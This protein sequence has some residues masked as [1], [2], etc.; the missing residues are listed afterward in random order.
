MAISQFIEKIRNAGLD[1]IVENAFL[2]YF[3]QVEEGASGKLSKNEIDAPAESNVINY[4]EIE[5]SKPAPIDKLAVIKLNGGLG[6]SMGLSQA[7]TLL[8]VKDNLNFLDIIA[9]QILTLRDQTQ[10]DIPLIF[11]HSF[12][13]QKDSLEYLE[14]YKDLK[15]ENIPLDFLQNKFPKVRQSD[16]AP[17]I[18]KDD[19]KTWNPPGHG[20][21][22]MALAITGTLDKLLAAGK[23]YAFLS[24][25]D[26]LG[27]VVDDKILGY[28]A[29]NNLPF[30]ME[31]CTRTEMDKKGG[32]LAQTHDGQLIL[33]ETAQCP[34]DEKD[35]FE[36][37]HYYKYFNTNNLWINLKI[38]KEELDK[39]GNFL[40][41]SLIIN[42]KEVDGIKVFQLESAMGAAISVFKNSKAMVVH[43]DRFAPVKKTDD[44]FVVRSD[45][46]KLSSNYHL[47]LATGK[48]PIV[49][50]DQKY[51][52]MV[53]EFETRFLA[54]VPSLK[55][56]EKFVL[57]GDVKFGKNVII[58][59]NVEYVTEEPVILENCVLE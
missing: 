8:K 19:A 47:K 43:R 55:D 11:M 27:S 49:R 33:R 34:E 37:V 10:H 48:Q 40:P 21:I 41:L 15:L 30:L 5:L 9:R 7:K 53:N 3:K 16:L 52:K 59:G 39:N 24:N 50:L 18:H 1:P 23:E 29:E 36:D 6:T 4:D 38:L 54:D 20:E 13:T 12:N 28:F 17:F 22:Y 42:P 35:L 2:Y 56:C 44:L 57:K 45:A 58:K 25:S 51:F 31:V 14:K 26:N 32:H 46:F